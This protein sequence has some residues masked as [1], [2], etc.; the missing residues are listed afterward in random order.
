MLWSQEE[1][2]FSQWFCCQEFTVLETVE[3]SGEKREK[4]KNIITHRQLI[5]QPQLLRLSTKRLLVQYC[6]KEVSLS[7]NRIG[8]SPSTA[9]ARR[10][11]DFL[12]LSATT[13]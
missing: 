8:T 12:L 4:K 9:S 3:N 11:M 13:M 6:R 7:A 10:A 5:L 1:N 2:R